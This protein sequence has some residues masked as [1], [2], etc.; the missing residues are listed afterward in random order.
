MMRLKMWGVRGSIPTPGPDTVEFGGNTSCFEVRGHGPS[1]AV[2]S[3]ALAT[4]EQEEPCPLCS[5]RPRRCVQPPSQG[6]AWLPRRAHAAA[7][8]DESVEGSHHVGS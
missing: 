1:L 8:D 7:E 6:R 2:P 5:I 3:P 4:R